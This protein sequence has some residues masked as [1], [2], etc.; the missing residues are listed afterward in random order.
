MTLINRYTAI[1]K[2]IPVATGNSLVVCGDATALNT[3]TSSMI[4]I[5]GNTT[6]DW[7]EA[8]SKANLNIANNSTILY[9]ELT[10]YSTVKSDAPSALDVRSIQDEPITFNTPK[11]SYQIQPQFTESFTAISG[12][13]DRFRSAVV[14]DKIIEGL[15]GDYSVAKVPTS[16]PATGLSKTRAGWSLVVFYKN[17]LFPP[18]KVI[19]T[20]GI[21]NA[22]STTPL[23]NTITGFETSG[24]DSNLRGYIYFACANGQPLDGSETVKVGPSFANLVTEGN[25]IGTPNPNPGTSPNNP[26]NSFFSGQINVCD[27]LQADN[28]GL[29]NINGTNGTINHDAFIPTQVVGARNKWDL[30]NIDISNSLVPNQ[31]QLAIQ[32]TES[33]GLDGVMLVGI[34]TIVNVAAPDITT[35]FNAFDA[36]GRLA[37]TAAVGEEIIYSLQ[38]KNSGKLEATNVIISSVLDPSTS[39]VP[40]S[41]TV[42]GTVIEGANISAG[43]N[44]GTIQSTGV[45]NI[46]FAVRINSLPASTKINAFMNYNYS[47]VS[48]SGSP[49]TTNYSTTSV[50]TID[51]KEAKI[52]ISKTASSTTAKI[53][54][55]LTY[56]IVINNTGTQLATNVL[57]QDI[58]SQYSSFVSGSVSINGIIDQSLNPSTGF[59]LGDM[60]SGAQ[61]TISFDVDIIQLPP[62]KIVYNS[63]KVTATYSAYSGGPVFTKTVFSNIL[64]I[65]VQYSDIVGEKC[66]NNDYPKIGDIVTYILSLTNIGNI[67][68]TNVQVAEPPI[69]GATFVSGTVVIDGIPKPL[70]NP[71]TGF[72]LDSISPQ[73]TVDIN[74]NVLV[75]SLNPNRLIENIAKIPFKYQ[76]QQ[77]DPVISSEKDS[78]KVTTMTS[79]VNVAMVETVDKAYAIIDDILYYSVSLTNTGNIDAINTLFISGIQSE[80]SF[81]PNTVTINGVVQPNLNPNL[82]FSIGTLCA[83][84]SIVVTY[85]SKV[86]SV[87]NPNIIYNSSQ[88]TY[89]YLPDP[90]GNTINNTVTSNT[91][92]TIINKMSFTITKT[93]DK[94]YAQLGDPVAYSISIVNTGTVTLK[95]VSFIDM[96]PPFV[97]LYPGQ[98]Y[99]NGIQKSDLNPNI[100]FTVG[101]IHPGDTVRVSLGIYINSI[102]P[103]GYVINNAQIVYT[104]QMNPTSEVVTQTASSNDVKTYVVNGNLNVT[105]A[106]NKS[107]ATLNDILNYSFNVSNTGNVKATNLNFIDSIPNGA[108]FVNGSVVINGISKP[109]YDPTSGFLLSDLNVGQV[110]NITFSAKITSVP[111][112]NTIINSGS[113]SFNYILIPETPPLSKTVTSNTVTTVINVSTTNLTKTVDKAYAAINDI[114]NYTLLAQNT[115]T[116]DI[117]NV[118]FQDIIPNGAT[119]VA[120]S[121]I[122]D[123]TSYPDYDL[124]VGFTRPVINPS[125]NITINFQAKVI[126]SPT[127]NTII[128]S[129]TMNY[130]YKLNPSGAELSGSNTSNTVT[131]VVNRV[132]VSNTKTVDKAYATIA[133]V[134]TYTSV[135]TNN[136]NIAINNVVFS[137][138]VPVGTTFKT[139]SVKID[140]SSQPTYDPSLTFPIGTIDA[141][142]N[143]TV[144]FKVDVASLPDYGYVFNTSKFDYDYKIDPNGQTQSGSVTSNAVNTFIN[145]GSLTITKAVDR[146]F[147]RK[148]DIVNYT[149]LITNTGNIDLKNLSFIDAIQAESS[150]NANS[151]Y[152]D[153]VNKPGLNPNIGFSLDNIPE[154]HYTT[155]TFAVTVNTIPASGKLYNIGSVTYSYNIDPEGPITT[156]TETSNQTTVNVNDT[157]VSATKSVDKAIAKIGDELTY[158]FIITNGGTTSALSLLFEDLLDSHISFVDGSVI[159]NGTPSPSADPNIGF[160]LPDIIA[161]GNNTVSFKATVISRPVN[162]IVYNFATINY[163]YRVSPTSPFIDVTLPTNTVETYVTTGELTI[164]KAVDRAYATLGNALSYSVTIKNSGSVNTTNLSF[165]DLIA[166]DLKFLA[167]SVIVNGVLQPTLNPNMG[168]SIPNLL[169]NESNVVSFVA[170]V[171]SLPSS[172]KVDNFAEITFS[173]KLTQD[174][175]TVTTTTNSNTVTTYINIGRLNVTKAV[176]SAYATIGDVLNYTVTVNNYGSVPCSSVTFKD[177][178]Q[179]EATFNSGSVKINGTSHGS[180]DPNIGFPLSDIAPNTTSTVTFSVTV[181]AVPDDSHIYN[182]ATVNFSYYVNPNNPFINTSAISNTV[183]TQVNLGK[184]TISKAVNL[185]Y[186]TLNDTI[187]YTVTVNNTGNIPAAF[188]NFR[189]VIPTG[190]SF[191]QN[192]VTIN[193]LPQPGYDPFESFTLGTI[194]AGDSVVVSFRATV[195]SVP[196]SSLIVNTATV[197]FTSRINPAGPDIISEVTSNAV[198][199]QINIGQLNIT[200]AVNKNYA[201]L[202]DILTYNFVVTNVGNVNTTNIFFNDS[203]ESGVAFNIGSVIVNGTSQPSYDP[204]A[205][206][207]LGNIP[208]LGQVTISFTVTV[209]SVPQQQSI[210]NYAIINYNYKIDPQGQTYTKSTN[211]NSVI[212]FIKIGKLS[213]AKTVNL[214]YATLQNE[215]LYTIVVTNSGNTSAYQL[216]FTDL[217]SNGATFVEG[218]VVVDDIPKPSYNPITGFYLTDLLS[219]NTSTVQFKAN[220]LTLP[221]PPQVIN[222]ATTSGFYKVAPEGPDYE[223]STISNTVTTQINVGN[224]TINKAVDKTYANVLDIL[225][226]T[227]T[228]TNTGNVIA[229]AVNFTDNLQQ[230]I[231]FISGT[232]RINGVTN[233]LLNPITGINLGNLAPTQSVTVEF[234]VKINSLPIPP[235]V[236]NTSQAQFSYKIDPNSSTITKTNFSNT[237]NT[238]IVLGQLTAVKT[239]DKLIA[240]IGDILNYT[241]TITNT[242][243]S[244]SSDVFFQDTPSTG[245]TFNVGSV[246]INGTSQSTFDPTSGFSLGDISVGNVVTVQ[247]SATVV[248]IPPTNKVTNQ[249]TINFKY[250]V[251]PKQPPVNKTTTSNTV[252]TNIAVGNLSVTKAVN[253]AYATIGD[254]LTYTVVVT[255]IG[256]INATNVVFLDQTPA[257]STFT[258][259]SVTINGVSYPSYNPS[260]GFD[261]GTMTPG[262]II[263]VVYN[264]QV[265]S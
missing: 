199:T 193:G 155:I 144:E 20:S 146:N 76:I 64:Q 187:I 132:T 244:L 209:T 123:G 10:W 88:L 184:L 259:G 115:G 133:D 16:L 107:Y 86:N 31:N 216:F 65:Q 19:F 260:V 61:N 243:N 175:P 30:T 81:I 201:T 160:S 223:V 122:V 206:F 180:Y 174:D 218:S 189:D 156:K 4:M 26:K 192:S 47:F 171:D 228:I 98:V 154:G 75:N 121:V 142:K 43:V 232:V 253:K 246:I 50:S 119:F 108:S 84:N 112:P 15:S 41:L 66:A 116:M 227:N 202:N 167:G 101:D 249:A 150:F 80:S 250:L 135:I 99:V 117:T 32:V 54:D 159:I 141:G 102:P 145:V 48:G 139:G 85:Q 37:N 113:V 188:V 1:D 225:T 59:S 235:I 95:N 93:A 27:P 157:I 143:V 55:R 2:I 17:D 224:I 25:I 71:F 78:N 125:G 12:N 34:G 166:S 212:T 211:S 92:Q 13:I 258:L 239:V 6:R 103:S 210:L 63:T 234:D 136:S 205:G 87:P 252:T 222:Y 111:N 215:L 149:F 251:D 105:K 185:A 129:G 247:F 220:V 62:S 196:N 28:N 186:A 9:A 240:T 265:V 134:L 14:T 226:Y 182:Y 77:S 178:I 56:N 72:T 261:L 256:N 177:I 197:T 241:V 120:G 207:N 89:G 35:T 169:P 18:R 51:I 68:A 96:L 262:Q 3:N 130:K 168:F 79:F 46:M 140:G 255:N 152:I 230:E 161:G 118:F 183:Q 69:F 213:A 40:N 74:Y 73:Q 124:N 208:T 23:Q 83:N 162:N 53:G 147:A 49:T 238:N 236:L 110:T 7:Q 131:T 42:N 204:T 106:V 190:L 29:I 21:A 11:G 100:G 181:N 254:T 245:A 138:L 200:K 128:N 242:G 38:I 179:G 148:T 153:G 257:N 151:V 229:S 94:L 109:D 194:I 24:D 5:N 137:D 219:G 82:G 91:V 70:L 176:D 127:P 191:I 8:G 164:T 231:S 233:P 170:M 57:F 126:S 237:V 36:D 33:G 104:Y 22:N 198:T 172:G 52:T 173:Y 97:A 44:I 264:V 60:A 39:F 263:T 163:Q 45:D 58:I 195:T 203:L 217:L 248:S 67:A 158:S 114:L 221:N 165:K 90:N 214:S